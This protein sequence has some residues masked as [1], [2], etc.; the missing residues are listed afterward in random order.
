[1]KSRLAIKLESV[2]KIRLQ[3]NP[4]GMLSM[5]ATPSTIT[6]SACCLCGPRAVQIINH[7]DG[8]EVPFQADMWCLQG[9]ESPWGQRNGPEETHRSI[10][11]PPYKFPMKNKRAPR[12]T[13]LLLPTSTHVL[14][15]FIKRMSKK[16]TKNVLTHHPHGIWNRKRL[17]TNMSVLPNLS[18]LL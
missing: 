1:M 13:Y 10:W 14:L 9:T 15:S 17:M 18:F 7:T 2:S 4:L 11:A 12:L 16:R 8:K 6:Q 5:L 3:S